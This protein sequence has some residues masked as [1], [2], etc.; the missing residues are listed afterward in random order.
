LLKVLAVELIAPH[1]RISIYAPEL[2][3][4][5]TR[6][7]ERRVERIREFHPRNVPIKRNDPDPSV[8]TEHVIVR[9]TH[10]PIVVELS[11]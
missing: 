5:L 1:K 10:H 9:L 6:G 8:V 7:G 2:Y 3:S 11:S 4:I